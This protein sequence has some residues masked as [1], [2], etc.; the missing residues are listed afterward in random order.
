MRRLFAAA[1]LTAATL[2]SGSAVGSAESAPPQPV[3]D[4]SC[5]VIGDFTARLTNVNASLVKGATLVTGKSD[6]FGTGVVFDV[7][8]VYEVGRGNAPVV[9]GRGFENDIVYCT[10]DLS[11][12]VGIPD[13]VVPVGIKLTGQAARSMR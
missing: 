7:Y 8:D 9:E 5:D 13:Y 10:V 4:V 11:D 3:V 1:V 2:L 12:V 6:A